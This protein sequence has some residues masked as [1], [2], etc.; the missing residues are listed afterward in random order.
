VYQRENASASAV[1]L[2]GS[3]PLNSICGVAIVC[4]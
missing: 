4:P 2:G 3:C 1:S